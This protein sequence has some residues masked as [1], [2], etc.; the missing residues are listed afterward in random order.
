MKKTVGFLVCVLF[1]ASVIQIVA[2]TD[3]MTEARIAGEND[4]KGFKWKWFAA[5]YVTTNASVIAIVLAIW[6][7]ENLVNH[8]FDTLH[9]DACLLAIYG[10]YTLAPTA[11][12]ILHAAT[13][14]ADRLLGKSP[15]WVNAYTK[16]YQKNMRRYRAESTAAGCVVGGAVLGA[17]LYQ[18]IPWFTGATPY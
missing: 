16:A 9:H 3:E 14:P 15:D 18:I 4:A 6:A 10:A 1:Y 17:T 13:P 7:N 12:A 8:A 5:G 2:S 11:I